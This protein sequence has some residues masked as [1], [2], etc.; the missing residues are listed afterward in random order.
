MVEGYGRSWE[1]F[2]ELFSDHVAYV[3]HIPVEIIEQG[4][5]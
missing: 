1:G 3:E 5:A 2:V 4:A